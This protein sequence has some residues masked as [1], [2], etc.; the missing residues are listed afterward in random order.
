MKTKGRIFSAL[1]RPSPQVLVQHG[2]LCYWGLTNKHR[3]KAKP[4]FS[5]GLTSIFELLYKQ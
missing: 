2:V 4:V 1:L 3:L 5:F